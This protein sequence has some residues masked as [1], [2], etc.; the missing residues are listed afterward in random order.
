MLQ[1]YQYTVMQ[2]RHCKLTSILVML[3]HFTH[4]ELVRSDFSHD[5]PAASYDHYNH[6]MVH[7]LMKWG[8][9]NSLL[10]FLF[11]S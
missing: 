4:T 9:I 1:P 10:L 11:L 3:Y 7:A 2:K 5:Q 8:A 6:C